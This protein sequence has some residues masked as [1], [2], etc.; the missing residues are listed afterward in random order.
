M[1]VIILF[2]QAEFKLR[3]TYKSGSQNQKLKWFTQEEKNRIFLELE[4]T[5]AIIIV[6]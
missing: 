5:L 3:L 2:N 1:R 6:T 4:G